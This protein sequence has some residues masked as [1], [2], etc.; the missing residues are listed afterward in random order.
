MPGGSTA[1]QLAEDLGS[2]TG[3]ALAKGRQKLERK[4]LDLIVV[5]D[6]LEPGAGMEVDTNRVAILG[7][8]GSSTIVPMGTKREVADAI[9]DAIEARLG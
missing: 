5:N 4:E 1:R 6:A 3:D 8:D 9:L 7:R 2:E